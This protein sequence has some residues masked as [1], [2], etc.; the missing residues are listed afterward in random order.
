ME[1]FADSISEFDYLVLNLRGVDLPV[2][3]SWIQGGKADPY[4]MFYK[5]SKNSAFQAPNVG[6]YMGEVDDKNCLCVHNG[7]DQYQSNT[8]DPV[9]PEMRIQVRDLCD[10]GNLRKPFLINV[11]DYDFECPNDDFMGFC[12]V[13]ILDL[14]KGHVRMEAIPLQPGKAGHKWG[15]N[16]FVDRIRIK[17]HQCAQNDLMSIVQVVANSGNIPAVCQLLEWNADI[18]TILVTACGGDDNDLP[19]MLE[20]FK[21]KNM[22]AAPRGVS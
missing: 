22:V 9:W 20:K 6:E 8:L 1:C 17:C 16:L 21:K 5:N 15:G 19:V 7:K 13:S 12:V 2:K 14:I 4:L 11:W 3:D 10:G 18:N